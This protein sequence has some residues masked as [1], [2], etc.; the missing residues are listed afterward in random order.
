MPLTDSGSPAG[1][2]AVRRHNLALVLQLLTER[3]RQSRAAIA[4]TTGLTRSTIGSLV[5]DLIDR[6]LVRD[7]GVA[8]DQHMGR[9]A[10]ML[11]IDGSHVAAIG[12]ELNVGAITTTVVDLAGRVL[13]E[14]RRPLHNE[15]R[16]PETSVPEVIREVNA[17]R[18]GVE[19]EVSII[20][21]GLAVAGLVDS[22]T[23]MVHVAPNLGWHD[24][25]LGDLLHDALRATSAGDVPITIDNEANLGAL[26]EHDQGR[27]VGIDDFIY[28]LGE[29]GVG[30]GV[31]C[32][33]M[34]VRG[35]DGYAGEIGHMTMVRDGEPCGCGSRGC[36]ETLVGL[37]AMLRRAAPDVA[38]A[39]ITDDSLNP[40][41]KVAVV[42]E[43]A[44][45][46]DATA[47]E[48]L[49]AIGEWLGVGVGNLI[50]TFNPRLVVIAGV[51]AEVA[52]WVVPSAVETVRH[53]TVA[54][55]SGGCAIVTSTLG[56]RAASLG[57][58]L[59]CSQRAR[60][61]PLSVPARRR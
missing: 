23:G 37:S 52:E 18:A 1:H 33:G 35:A 12:M 14:Q 9:P 4:A 41:A 3:G 55:R 60:A 39:V 15:Q 32:N 5:G 44:R 38:E 28:L 40:E 21:I 59:R 47:L 29:R 17:V 8:P 31:V 10:R 7:V 22:Q 16:P 11:D 56:H 27:A 30:G 42:V 57:A 20:G 26:A 58:A 6:G 34:L 45:A 53:R 50:D 46:R 43:R 51:L 25:P 36:W 61:D 13:V 48:A 19:P 2:G 54:A 24:A 49:D